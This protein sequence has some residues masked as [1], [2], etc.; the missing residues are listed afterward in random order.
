MKIFFFLNMDINFASLVCV[1]GAVVA[2][3]D[4]AF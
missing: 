3:K 4:L 2:W 1:L